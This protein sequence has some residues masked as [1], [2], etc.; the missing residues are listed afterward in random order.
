MTPLDTKS[1][2][3]EKYLSR[4]W[5]LVLKGAF[6]RTHPLFKGMLTHLCHINPN[7]INGPNLISQG[8][9]DETV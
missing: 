6:G 2:F 4:G 7:L 8:P 9:N 1:V 3:K 5:T